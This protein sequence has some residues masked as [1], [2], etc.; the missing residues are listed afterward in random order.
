MAVHDSHRLSVARGLAPGSY[1]QEILQNRAQ[2]F[3]GLAQAITTVH[4][5]YRTPSSSATLAKNICLLYGFDIG[6]GQKSDNGF[7]WEFVHPLW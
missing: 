3:N 5:Q 7:Q 2:N 1:K 6:I 4:G